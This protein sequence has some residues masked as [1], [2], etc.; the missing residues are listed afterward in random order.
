MCMLPKCLNGDFRQ[1]E[2]LFFSLFVTRLDVHYML[3]EELY[4]ILSD[5]MSPHIFVPIRSTGIRRAEK[6]VANYML[7]AL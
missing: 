7:P 6:I 3:K 5:N 1:V 4:S 2:G